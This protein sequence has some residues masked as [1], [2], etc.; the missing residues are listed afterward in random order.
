MLRPATPLSILLFVAFVLLLLSVIST[1]VVKS[2]PLATFDGVDYGVFGFCS[3][4]KCSGIKIGY[5]T[6]NGNDFT[7]PATTRHSLST[8]LV[9][10]PVAAF[11]TLVCLILS[12][13]AHLH[14]PSHSPRYL[15][16]L[17]IL[18]LPTLLITLLAFL[19]DILLFVPHLQWG[20]WIV[21]ASTILI[22]ASGVVTCAMRRTLVSRKARKKR[23]AENAEMS[24]ENYYNQQ[25]APKDKFAAPPPLS[26]R[27][28]T[29]LVN[30]APGAD[31]LP[32]FTVFN[33]SKPPTSEDDRT[34][35]NARNPSSRT[36]TNS[37]SAY[38]PGL[39]E[40]GV[41]RYGGPERGGGFA[42]VRGGRGGGPYRGPRDEFGNPLPPSTAFGTGP[43]PPPGARRN[44]QDSFNSQS[45]RGRGR[46]GYPPRGYGRGG[47]YN[48]GRGGPQG[49]NETGRGIPL[50]AMAAGTG[51]GVLAADAYGNRPPPPGYANG[52]PPQSRGGPGQY[53][54]Q[55]EQD[56]LP[57]EYAQPSSYARRQ[58]PGPPS[59]PGYGR[60]QSPGPPSA[61]GYGRQQSPG[62]PSAP[63]Y[64]YGARNQ[65]PG[66]NQGYMRNGLPPPLPLHH[67]GEMPVAIGQ[68]VEMDATTGSPN[69]RHGFEP[70]QPLRDSDSDVQGLVGLQQNRGF[71][72]RE[73]NPISPTS[74]YSAADNS[75]VPARS[76]WAGGIVR[77][78]TPPMHQQSAY[79]IEPTPSITPPVELSATN[80]VLGTPP[81]HY[82]QPRGQ[83]QVQ[84]QNPSPTH[85]RG[86]SGGDNYYED[87]DPR[88]VETAS[89]PQ[90]VPALLLP[91][92][93][94]SPQIQQQ[95]YSHPII[96]R[97]R[98][99]SESHQGGQQGNLTSQFEPTSS[100]ESI[101]EGSR[102]PA[103]SDGSH[104]T[105]ISQRGV[106]PDW[107]PPPPQGYQDGVPNR[108]PVQ[109]QR[110]VLLQG[111]P[112][113][114]LP[115]VGAGARGPRRGG[116]PYVGSAL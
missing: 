112:D 90:T 44:S 8:L 83:P 19:V 5:S 12:L 1:P 98:L 53:N 58:S 86:V 11:L 21:L 106:N 75:Y 110:D 77:N 99:N 28:T 3:G 9:V 111:N 51:A 42:G 73:E 60:R 40:D 80:S 15:L 68:A 71:I 82:A 25:S 13:T 107:R 2:I 76:A 63:G 45:S 105:S 65:S 67:Q 62:P 113:F 22:V 61:P 27:P 41:D 36:A 14:S 24:G 115:G 85:T 96:D 30:G 81:S 72:P 16:A 95:P 4:S 92:H 103:A 56:V 32:D 48:G 100:Y 94:G 70:F 50:G 6:A 74:T 93:Q 108:R 10:H 46:G 18:L 109:Q 97:E 91:G 49:Y 7:L 66:G 43:M 116:G 55:Y 87:V 114:E 88:F 78:N 34:P 31:K 23:I 17:I 89:E 20:G 69:H 59:A 84:V 35:L 47:P 38:V 52:Y 64:V 57:A 37:S 79:P 104:F 33:A 102:S 101:Q 39:Q 26:Q 29:P 54:Q